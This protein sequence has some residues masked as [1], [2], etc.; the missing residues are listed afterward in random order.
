MSEELIFSM[1]TFFIQQ[2]LYRMN[3]MIRQTVPALDSAQATGRA[4]DSAQAPFVVPHRAFDS[5][6]A[7]D[8]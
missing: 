7:P 6:Q 5:A 4:F 1:K 2:K 8:E 3:T